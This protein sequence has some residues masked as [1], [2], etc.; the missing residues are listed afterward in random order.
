MRLLTNWRALLFVFEVSVKRILQAVSFPFSSSTVSRSN[1]NLQV[2]ILW[3][4][5]NQRTQ[6]K[7]LG[8]RREPTTNSTHWWEANAF[9]TA[10]KCNFFF[11]LQFISLLFLKDWLTLFFSSLSFSFALFNPCLRR[12]S[13]AFAFSNSL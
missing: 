8:A 4:E 6:R 7:T 5:E 3:R 1:W 11:F 9:T 13:S 12:A 10:Q 2:L